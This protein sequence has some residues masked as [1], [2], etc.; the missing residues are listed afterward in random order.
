MTVVGKRA[1]KAIKVTGEHK[2]PQAP[3]DRKGQQDRWERRGPQEQ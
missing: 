1:T 2:G 3:R